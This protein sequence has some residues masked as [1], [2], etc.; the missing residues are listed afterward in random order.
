MNCINELHNLRPYVDK[1]EKPPHIRMLD[2]GG[3]KEMTKQKDKDRDKDKA[4]KTR[5]GKG[6]S[7]YR[8][9]TSRIKQRKICDTALNG[10]YRWVM[11]GVID[12][13]PLTSYLPIV[14][15]RLPTYAS[16]MMST[17]RSSGK[18]TAVRIDDSKCN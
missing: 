15:Q 14:G 8:C 6:H 18:G 4:H 5:Q 17:E 1:C 9:S 13:S 7:K 12:S 3:D 10:Q 11:P 16:R 2:I